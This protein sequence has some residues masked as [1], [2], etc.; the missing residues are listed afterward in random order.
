MKKLL[1]FLIVVLIGLI[2]YNY[3]KTGTL[4]IIPARPAP[5]SQQ[6]DRLT[7]RFHTLVREYNNAGRAAAISGLDT[8]YDAGAIRLKMLALQENV[9]E[10]ALKLTNPG[11]KED[12]QKLQTQIKSFLAQ[13]Q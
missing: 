7:A 10:L 6:L 1:L 12:L 4:R 11:E 5:A 13:L 8:S 3:V 2:A 9:D